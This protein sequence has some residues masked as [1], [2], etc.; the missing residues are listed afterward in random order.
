M[1][2]ISPEH[3][4]TDPEEVQHLVEARILIFKEYYV[5]GNTG[6]DIKGGRLGGELLY[7]G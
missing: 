1:R 5:F 4:L 6:A 3:K 2:E 7:R